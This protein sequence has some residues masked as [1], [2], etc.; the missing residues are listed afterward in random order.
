MSIRL[1]RLN[2]A[3]ELDDI[4]QHSFSTDQIPLRQ[5]RYLL[6]KAK[7]KTWV[8]ER[9]NKLAGYCM[10]LLPQLP[11]PA[12]LYS[13]AVLS[14]YRGM[15]VANRLIE[16]MLADIKLCGYTRVRLEVRAS[17]HK[18]QALYQK[19]GFNPVEQ[20]SGYYADGEDAFRMERPL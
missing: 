2:D 11:R 5:M 1:A 6:D 7:A 8:L 9:D 15:G 14:E 16:T 13:I 12:R 17:Q 20:I 3:Q 4:E 10:V 19:F 18:V